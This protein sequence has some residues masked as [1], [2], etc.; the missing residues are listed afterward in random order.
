MKYLN[1]FSL[2]LLLGLMILM[3]ACSAQDK[4]SCSE[5]NKSSNSSNE[6][7]SKHIFEI[8]EDS[9]GNLWFGTSKNGAARYDGKTLTYFTEEDGLCGSSV[10]NIA[11]DKEGNLWFGTHMDL[12]KYDG[13]KFQT[14]ARKDGV[15]ILGWG[16]K[17]MG[18]G[19]KSVR[20]NSDQSIWVNSHHGMFR[21]DDPTL[22]I[23]QLR[24]TEFEVPMDTAVKGSYCNTPGK[25]SLDLED[26][27]GNLW[28]GTDGDGAYKYDGESF[29]HYS[30]EDGLLTNNVTNIV[31]DVK[32]NIW[33]ACVQSLIPNNMNDGGLCMYNGK[34]FTTFSDMEGLSQNNIYTLY[35]DRSGNVWIGANGVGVYRYDPSD[36]PADNKRFTLYKEPKEAKLETRF[37]TPGLQSILEDSNG[38][39][40]LGYSGGLFRLDGTSIV[41]VTVDGPW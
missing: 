21:C 8:F 36:E 17:N 5:N 33:F 28:F 30:K 29:T 1:H 27:N 38:T 39:I 16:W 14:L 18:A 34:Q 20:T 24:F 6:Q 12:C 23:D 31:E 13:T 26:R 10:A 15:P 9:K 37:N 11:E 22:Q 19:W 32:G 40:W 2:A 3:S 7:I 35:E 41:N 25:I 4:A